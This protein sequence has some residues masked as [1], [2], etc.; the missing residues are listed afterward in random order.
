MSTTSRLPDSYS[1]RGG[2]HSPKSSDRGGRLTA[3]HHLVQ[4]LVMSGVKLPRPL[5]AFMA[6]RGQIYLFILSLSHVVSCAEGS[7][8]YLLASS[9]RKVT[10]MHR[11]SACRILR[12][13]KRAFVKYDTEKFL[14]KLVHIFEFWCGGFGSRAIWTLEFKPRFPGHP[15]TNYNDCTESFFTCYCAFLPGSFPFMI[16]LNVRFIRRQST[17]LQLIYC[18]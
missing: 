10:R 13:T 11:L 5:Y 17:I 15:A 14:L 18:R 12:A 2:F 16:S 1:K 9:I 6:E 8:C 7:F 3:I 4:S